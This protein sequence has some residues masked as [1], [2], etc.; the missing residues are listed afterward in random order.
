MCLLKNIDDKSGSYRLWKGF[1]LFD[2]LPLKR[3]SVIVKGAK[4]RCRII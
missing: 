4:Y 2:D 3:S 1:R